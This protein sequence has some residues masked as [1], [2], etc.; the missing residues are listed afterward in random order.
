LPSAIPVSRAEPIGTRPPTVGEWETRL[1]RYV[2]NATGQ[3]DAY[4]LRGRIVARD[5]SGAERFDRTGETKWVTARQLR[6]GARTGWWVIMV[7]PARVIAAREGRTRAT[8][9]LATLVGQQL[10]FGVGAAVVP[11]LI[12]VNPREFHATDPLTGTQL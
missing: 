3:L 1:S 11:A 7:P 2:Y 12:N 4:D 9:D 8:I 10:D 5:G 6:R